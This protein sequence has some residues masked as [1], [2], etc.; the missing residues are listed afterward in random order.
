MNIHEGRIPQTD[1]SGSF[2]WRIL[3]NNR[4]Q[5][6][7]IHQINLG[8]EIGDTVKFD[9]Y[10]FPGSC[11]VPADYE[12]YVVNQYNM[13]IVEFIDEV[14]AGKE[15]PV[16]EEKIDL[17][18]FWPS[19]DTELNGYID[20]NWRLSD[21]EQFVCAFDDPYGG[22][23]TFLNG[24]KVRVKHCETTMSDGGFHPFQKGVVYRIDCDRVFVATED[25]GLIFGSII[26]DNG[27]DIVAEVKLGD[28][29]LTPDRYLEEG[30]KIRNLAAC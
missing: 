18:K 22:A 6:R 21:I 1:V 14:I 12:N 24:N 16:F 15:F 25:G 10:F 29:F 17:K 2:S 28:R 20:W 26:R 19:L 11:R 4:L 9:E 5:Y 13:L 27:K 23:S 3:R 7:A 30:K 8:N